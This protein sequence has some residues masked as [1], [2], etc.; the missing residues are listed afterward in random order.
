[1][2]FKNF[3][4]FKKAPEFTQ[5]V[6]FKYVSTQL[7]IHSLTNDLFILLFINRK[8]KPFKHKKE[9]YRNKILFVFHLNCEWQIFDN[10]RKP[11]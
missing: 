11:G 5:Y 6:K 2:F 7:I 8:K 4:N 10:I 3:K 9:I 1:M